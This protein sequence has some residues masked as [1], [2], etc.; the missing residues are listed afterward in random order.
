MLR[1][2]TSSRRCA[3]G[4]CDTCPWW[5]P[6]RSWA[7]SRCATCAT[8]SLRRAARSAVRCWAGCCTWFPAVASFLVR[9]SSCNTDT[10]GK[11]LKG[12]DYRC[13]VCGHQFVAVKKRDGVSDAAILKAIEQV[14]ERGTLYYRPEHLAYR[15][16]RKLVGA[17][18]SGRIG[19][20]VVVAIIV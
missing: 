11:T 16:Q 6:A 1:H 9:C 3:S 17:G 19:C 2:S 8:P 15:L 12:T 13:P 14:S 7:W 18:K 20:L 10:P 4:A 5:R